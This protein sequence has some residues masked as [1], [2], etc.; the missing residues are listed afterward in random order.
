MLLSN[1]LRL[2]T[3]GIPNRAAKLI[4][5][6]TKLVQTKFILSHLSTVL[7][8]ISSHTINNA[9]EFKQQSRAVT[10]LH[11]IQLRNSITNYNCNL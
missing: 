7:S 6:Q 2:K 3:F 4:F 11:V 10:K 8:I 9:P 1:I 5:V